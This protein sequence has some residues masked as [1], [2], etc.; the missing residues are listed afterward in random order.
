MAVI[1]AADSVCHKI[2][3]EKIL[4]AKTFIQRQENDAHRTTSVDPGPTL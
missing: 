4:I 3:T 1:D 2:T